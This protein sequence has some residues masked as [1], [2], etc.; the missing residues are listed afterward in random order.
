[1]DFVG[2]R[3]LLSIFFAVRK[4]QVDLIQSGVEV[5]RRRGHACKDAMVA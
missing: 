4:R 3:F 5:I 2:G 1:M